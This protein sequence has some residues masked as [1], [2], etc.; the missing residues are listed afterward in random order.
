MTEGPAAAR[1][2]EW[3]YTSAQEDIA[4]AAGG[5]GATTILAAGF[6]LAFSP[7]ALAV[8][9]G[10][11]A[12]RIAP[13][14]V[15]C[16]VPAYRNYILK[17][18]LASG[19]GSTLA[20]P[21]S[22]IGVIVDCLA[23]KL[24]WKNTPQVILLDEKTVTKMALP[25]GLRWLMKHEETR[26][27]ILSRVFL[28]QPA[29]QF[30]LT[31]EKAIETFQGDALKYVAAHELSHI[32]KDAVSLPSYIKPVMKHFRNG[33]VLACLGAG[34]LSLAG[35]ALPVFAGSALL[36]IASLVVVPTAASVA[37]N[38]GTRVMERR[39][40]R[41]ALYLTEN[42]AAAVQT[43]ALLHNEPT[44]AA[45]RKSP[46]VEMFSTHPT[47]LRRL[48]AL[49]HS[50]EKVAGHC[51]AAQHATAQAENAVAVTSRPSA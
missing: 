30:V 42:Y 9:G 40:D 31:T 10:Y 25:Y 28:A 51:R 2:P 50:F 48:E 8:A 12:L 15:A 7:L 24:E 27:N 13:T 49:M 45:M 29:M 5:L 6:A 47:H 36:G 14:L 32:Q 43:M 3:R 35:V 41:N 23:K 39:A 11:C 26:N 1:S 34:A 44:H 17:K 21:D 22:E 37:N 18:M 33:L 4:I 19:R 20:A 16:A 38:Y 46:L